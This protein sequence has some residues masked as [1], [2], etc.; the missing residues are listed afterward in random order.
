MNNFKLPDNRDSMITQLINHHKMHILPRYEKLFGYYKG[1]HAIVDKSAPLSTPNNKIVNPYPAFIVNTVQGY[2]L[3]QPVIYE[4]KNS[5]YKDLLYSIFD[6]NN[7]DDENVEI[8]KTLSITG[9]A[10]ELIY[11][12][13][14]AEVQFVQ[15]P[16]TQT[17]VHYT[18]DLK[19]RIDMALRYYEEKE[20]GSAD[21]TLKVELYLP[22]KIMYF[23]KVKDTYLIDDEQE[24]F[25]KEVP[26]V[27]YLNN[28]EI[29]GDFEIALPLID[30]Y[31]NTLSNNSNEFEYFRNAY[32]ILK[33]FDGT[34]DEELA[35]AVQKRAFKTSAEGDI[36]F[37]TKEINDTAIM[38][39]L[40]V[41]DQN[42]H[43]ACNIPNLTDENFASNLSGVALK[44]KLWGFEN[45]IS[46]KER[47]FNQS[48]INRIKLITK[49]LNLKGHSFD[50]KEIT[51]KFT[52]NLPE[53]ILEQS[54]IISN[55]KDV[56]PVEFLVTLLPFIDNKEEFLKR[57]KEM[58]EDRSV[59]NI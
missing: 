13:E 29:T 23:T 58:S 4:S 45:L 22:D 33:G 19:P 50:W 38:N 41:L 37:L 57:L 15:L 39:H 1:H 43:K 12:D 24:H 59:D 3:G 48:L 25:F 35:D 11:L 46:A 26:V 40:R 2:F 31:D 18:N 21:A 30:D 52:R 36:S 9:E 7:E 5:V 47:K 10:F 49:A 42:I 44:Y 27:H 51:P 17:I 8:E 14:K 55:L 32:L 6:E 34:T 20:A 28:K 56:I 16:N 53:N 54:V